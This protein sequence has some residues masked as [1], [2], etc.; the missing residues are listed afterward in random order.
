VEAAVAFAL[1]SPD[2]TPASAL[3]HV[4]AP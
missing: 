2:P 4:F 3:D 1:A